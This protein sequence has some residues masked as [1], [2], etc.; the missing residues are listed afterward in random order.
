[1]VVQ[2]EQVMCRGEGVRRDESK[3]GGAGGCESRVGEGDGWEVAE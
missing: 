3:V 2:G 1:M